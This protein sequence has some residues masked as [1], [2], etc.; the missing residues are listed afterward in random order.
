MSMEDY[1]KQGKQA[2]LVKLLMKTSKTLEYHNTFVSGN[3]I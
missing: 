2:Q 3:Y 1:P